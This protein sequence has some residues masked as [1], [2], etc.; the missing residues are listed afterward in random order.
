MSTKH[1]PGPWTVD[2]H[3]IKVKD[4]MWMEIATV[5]GAETD[6]LNAIN[7]RLIASAPDLLDALRT[8]AAGRLDHEHEIHDFDNRVRALARAAIAKAEGES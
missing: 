2:G 5:D 1:T 6:G 4:A 3:I 8:V 7:A